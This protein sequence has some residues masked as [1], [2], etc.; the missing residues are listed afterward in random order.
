MMNR[1]MPE[2][3]QDIKMALDHPNITMTE[4]ENKNDILMDETLQQ[5]VGYGFQEHILQIPMQK[6]MQLTL[7]NL[8]CQHFSQ[9]TNIQRKASEI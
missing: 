2:V 3:P 1:K 8:P 4:F 9:M 5:E 6:R 7:N